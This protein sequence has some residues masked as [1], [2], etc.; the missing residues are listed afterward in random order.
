M[1]KWA[2]GGGGGAEA[3]ISSPV[4]AAEG[5]ARC[6]WPVRT[7]GD[8]RTV[9]EAGAGDLGARPASAAASCSARRARSALNV[10]C[11]VEEVRKERQRRIV[12]VGAG[13]W[14]WA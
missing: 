8:W 10:S 14:N 6:G 4:T 5:D 2:A 11:G 7:R 3:A 9:R 12:K 1:S 13:N